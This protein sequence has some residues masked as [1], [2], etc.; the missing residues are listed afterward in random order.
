[1]NETLNDRRFRESKHSNPARFSFEF[2]GMHTLSPTRHW[3]AL[4]FGSVRPA[5]VSWGAL[6]PARGQYDWHSL[7]TWV[8]ESQKHN[9]QLD[10][11]FVNTPL[12]ASTRPNEPCIGKR[13]GCAAPPNLTDWEDFVQTLVKRYKGRISS[14]E[15]WNEPNGSG[16]W[17][18]SLPQM[19]ELAARAYPIINQL[20][21][22]PSLLL[23]QHRPPAG[24]FLTANP[25]SHQ[26]TVK[27]QGDSGA[28]REPRKSHPAWAPQRNDI[29]CTE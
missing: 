28:A 8:S 6:E 21:L 2:M 26:G 9:V 22:Q 12:W 16:F 18:G 4:P 23:R 24:P 11:V 19:V 20:I 25:L 15:L 5:G 7:D 29:A 3:P 10:Y 13:V 14:Y 27:E 17:T 1:M